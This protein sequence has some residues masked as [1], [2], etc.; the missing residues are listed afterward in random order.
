VLILIIDD[1]ADKLKRL[2]GCFTA[3]GLARDSIHTARSSRGAVQ[4][5][6][7][8]QYDLVILDLLLPLRDEEEA[9]LE[10]SLSLL[11]DIA[12]R[13]NIIKPRRLIG[14]TAYEEAELSASRVFTENLWTIVKYEPSSNEWME[15]FSR[16]YRYIDKAGRQKDRPQYET[17]ICVLTA[18]ADPELTAVHLLP[19]NWEAAEP[20]DD[21]TFIRRGRLQC[22]GRE[23]S[24]VSACAPRMGN[25]ASALLTSQLIRQFR[26]RIVVMAG[27][28]AGIRKKVSLGDVVLF[29]PCWEWASGKLVPGENDGT[30]LEPAPHQLP[31]PDFVLTRA[32]QLRQESDFWLR[33]RDGYADHP[34]ALPKLVIGPGA[35]GPAVVA[36]EEYTATLTAQHRLL[37]AIDME[38]YGV[39]A[40]AYNC[41]PPR[42]I[43]FAM[44][45]VCD[46][47]D[48]AKDDAFQ[49]YAAYTSAQ[50]VRRFLESFADEIIRAASAQG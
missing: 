31:V 6:S 3:L 24:V 10:V 27:I 46:F 13:D 18:L 12:E 32:M 45:S 16:V 47:A 48:E 38:A 34:D 15:Q 17:D 7:S 41:G 35:S 43:A 11:E 30:Y 2:I 1:D 25:V 42:P 44:K 37:T 40:A 14:F 19:W 28:C 29:T 23:L 9:K 36:S 39:C 8:S 26:P 4:M 20:M 5:L 33:V 22:G 21:S 49:R 50:A